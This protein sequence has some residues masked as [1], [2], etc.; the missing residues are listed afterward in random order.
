M[1]D[2]MPMFGVLRAVVP[3]QP[4]SQGAFNTPCYR[5]RITFRVFQVMRARIKSWLIVFFK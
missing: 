4:A 2:C 5:D 3:R 1:Y